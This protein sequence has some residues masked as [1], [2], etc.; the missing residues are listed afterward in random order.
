[1]AVVNIGLPEQNGYDV[2]RAVRDT[3]RND[4]VFMIALTG[5]GSQAD[6]RAAEEAGFDAH[7]TKP[8]EPERLFRLLATRSPSRAR[9][10]S[11]SWPVVELRDS[12]ER[13]ESAE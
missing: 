12:P 2:A 13:N 3:K 11:G 8:A 7:L 1:M 5:Y 6:V 9:S 4:R 10:G